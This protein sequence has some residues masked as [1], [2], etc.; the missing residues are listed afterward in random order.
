MVMDTAK[1]TIKEQALAKQTQTVTTGAYYIDQTTQPATTYIGYCAFCDFCTK[2]CSSQRIAVYR[3]EQHIYYRHV[4]DEA[5]PRKTATK[6]SAEYH[7]EER[8][9]GVL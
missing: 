4:R 3:I 5:K 6:K 7:D 9:A 2:P 1:M 8:I